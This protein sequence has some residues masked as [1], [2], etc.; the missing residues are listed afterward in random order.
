MSAE[1]F[2]EVGRL[3]REG[4]R[5]VIATVIET[6]GSTPRK[7]GARMA[8]LEDG[9]IRGSVGGG[10]LE[11]LVLED[12]R[13]LAASGGIALREYSL[14][15]G[16]GAGETGMVCGG[17]ARVHFQVEIPPERLLIFGAGHVGAALARQGCILGFDVTVLDDR[18]EFLDPG[19][20]PPHISLVRA[21]ELFS[22]ELPAVDP[23]C[24][25]AIVTRCHRTDLAAL[26]RVAGSGAA[27]VGLIGSRRKIAVVMARLRDEGIP[28][29]H[30]K[31][32]HAPIGLPIGACTPEEIAVSIAGELIQIRRDAAANSAGRGLLVPRPAERRRSRTAASD[33]S[34]KGSS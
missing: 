15:E 6:S 1:F 13:L 26:R 21:G 19:R 2:E 28:D 18:P 17:R 12:A 4:R 8:V 29:E 16:T 31:R 24:Y 33:F 30:L 5:V 7:A 34:G 11:A 32:I 9:S 14:R 27:Y 3:L 10:A 20:F 25:I 23:G 22:G